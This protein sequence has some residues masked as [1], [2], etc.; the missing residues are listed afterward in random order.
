MKK[1]KTVKTYQR[2]TKSGKIVTVRQ[3]TA[4]YDAAEALKEAT[5]KKGAGDE[6][7]AL[8]KKSVDKPTEEEVAEFEKLL[9]SFPEEL[10]ER[11]DRKSVV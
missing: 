3:H 9:D 2:R 1:E 4:K 11:S 6:L 7:E 5:K 10:D 8:K